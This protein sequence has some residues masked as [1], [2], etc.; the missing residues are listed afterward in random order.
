M[1]SFSYFNSII[2]DIMSKRGN[3]N[4]LLKILSIF[5][6]LGFV[7]FVPSCVPTV[8][9][10]TKP[11]NENIGQ[12]VNNNPSDN[13]DQEAGVFY[14]N[15]ELPQE[16]RDYYR[17]AYGLK[18]EALKMEL[19]NI[20]RTDHT[21]KGY[22]FLWTA[23]LTTDKA[24]NG[25]V[26]DMYSNT[27]ELGE[28]AAYW[29]VFIENQDKGSGSEEGKVYNREH[30]WP[31]STFGSTESTPQY[32]DIHHIT[33]VD[34]IVNGKRS[35]FAYGEVKQ[36]SFISQNGSKL[37][38][39]K[40][41]LGANNTVF[42]VVDFYKGDHARMHFYTSVRYYEDSL[43]IDCDWA[44]TGARLKPWYNEMLYEW[45]TADPVSQKEID[46]NNEI[47]KLQGNR[48]PFIDYPEL[49]EL[50]DFIH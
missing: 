43:F 8:S 19:Q 24:P 13:G 7:F 31:K 16:I 44:S 4:I 5:I 38:T 45:N 1:K 17:S 34:K 29:F 15:E 42:E 41:N 32:S 30:T 22:G 35:N 11:G 14:E 48:N 36:P 26:W 3:K 9:T 2:G 6:I 33:P 39:P 47:Y 40:D 46:R 12:D 25:K 18:G 20:I 50:I 27:S 23:F 49:I 21:N 28:T 37:G 10:D